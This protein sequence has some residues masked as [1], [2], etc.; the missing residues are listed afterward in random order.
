MF[1]VKWAFLIWLFS[2]KWAPLGNTARRFFKNAKII[3][4]IINVPEEII[5]GIG[6]IWSTLTCGLPIDATKFGDFC[7]KF[8]EKYDTSSV[9]WYQFSPTIHK[10]GCHILYFPHFAEKTVLWKLNMLWASSEYWRK[11][12]KAT[13][14]LPGKQ[15][16]YSPNKSLLCLF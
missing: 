9:N 8:V 6:T 10:G 14:V 3:S 16:I 4:K 5:S 15:L 2:Q 7:E 12:K 13:I 11:D 1:V